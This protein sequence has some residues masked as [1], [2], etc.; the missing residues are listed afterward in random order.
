MADGFVNYVQEPQVVCKQDQ[1]LRLRNG[2]DSALAQKESTIRENNK[3][4]GKRVLNT[5]LYEEQ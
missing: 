4:V 3:A 5:D 1:L 2:S